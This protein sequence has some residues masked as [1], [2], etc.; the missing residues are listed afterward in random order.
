MHSQ[1]W[2]P[3]QGRIAGMIREVG[4]GPL[5]SH[6]LDGSLHALGLP[7]DAR[8]CVCVCVC[9][10]VLRRDLR[11]HACACVRACMHACVR[12]CVLACVRACVR[13]RACVCVR[14]CLNPRGWCGPIHVP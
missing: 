10:C 8:V 3:K 11:V 1:E 13:V 7:H 4:A 6:E 5:F 14:A 12:A 9:V 2:F